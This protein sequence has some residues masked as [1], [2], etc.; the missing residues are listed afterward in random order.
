MDP[1]TDFGFFDSS[2]ASATGVAAGDTDSG[3]GNTGSNGTANAA[4]SLQFENVQDTHSA[5][6]KSGKARASGG[7][8]ELTVGKIGWRDEVHNV[9]Y[10]GFKSKDATSVAK[11]VVQ[12][13]SLLD[14]ENEDDA[15][16]GQM[17]TDIAIP[18]FDEEGNEME[19]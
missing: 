8:A 1:E 5:T 14:Y 11:P 4:T 19:D 16:S 15:A 6:T 2:D 18:R 9:T 13:P 17:A 7:G 12:I 3:T 10:L